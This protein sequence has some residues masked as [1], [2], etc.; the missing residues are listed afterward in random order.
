MN[1]ILNFEDNSSVEMDYEF[2]NVIFAIH[3]DSKLPILDQ[4]LLIG[5]LI[6]YLDKENFLKTITLKS[7]YHPGD[8]DTDYSPPEID[9]EDEYCCSLSITKGDIYFLVSIDFH[10]PDYYDLYHDT[11]PEYRVKSY[12]YSDIPY[13]STEQNYTFDREDSFADSIGKPKVE[14]I[15]EDY[16]IERTKYAPYK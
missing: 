10:I 9:Y 12:Q 13:K 3:S 5:C 11:P 4:E 8:I 15:A 7:F 16:W 2:S 6:E 14:F 1:I